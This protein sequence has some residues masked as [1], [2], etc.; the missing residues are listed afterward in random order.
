M[1]F[2]EVEDYGVQIQDYEL[3]ALTN[4]V[5]ALRL[6]SELAAQAEMESY[7]RDRFDV[8]VI[9]SK[10][11]DDRNKLIVMYLIDM[12]LYHLFSNL[13]PRTVPDIRADRY[14]AAID[15]LRRVAKGELNPG[16]PLVENEDGSTNGTSIFGSSTLP[17]YNW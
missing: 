11:A 5:D 4:G 9:F 15:W 1:P 17:G 12:A 13:T 3:D 8:A 7:L 2:L 16:L 14:R 10:T 6:K